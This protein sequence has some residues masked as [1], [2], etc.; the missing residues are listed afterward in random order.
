MHVSYEVSD[1]PD[2]IHKSERIGTE[3]FLSTCRLNTFE[4]KEIFSNR[5][6]IR[7][8]HLQKNHTHGVARK[9]FYGWGCHNVK[10][11]LQGLSIRRVKNDCP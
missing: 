8:L 3:Q 11:Y 5:L 10:N 2:I 4:G 1:N 9:Y 6:H 7:Y